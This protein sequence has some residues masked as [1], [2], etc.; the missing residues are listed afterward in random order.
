M[1]DVRAQMQLK[2]GL[3]ELAVGRPI[4]LDL[5]PSKRPTIFKYLHTSSRHVGY[6]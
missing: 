2:V 1:H 4:P 3:R 5:T 6:D